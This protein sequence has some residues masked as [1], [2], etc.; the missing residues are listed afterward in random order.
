MAALL[1]DGTHSVLAM[2]PHADIDCLASAYA[3]SASFRISS[4]WA[5]F[6]LDKFA[7]AAAERYAI[8][9]SPELPA[10]TRRVIFVDT[11][12]A[13]AAEYPDLDGKEIFIIDHHQTGDTTRADASFI[14]VESPSCSELVVEILEAGGIEPSKEVAELLIM[15]ILF[16]TGRFRRGKA[17]TL[18]KCAS[19]LET[20]GARLE[21]SKLNPE[22]PMDGSEQTAILKGMQRMVFRSAGGCIVCCSH[23]SAY[24]SSVASAL[25]KTGCDVAFVASETD[26]AVRVTGRSGPK[27][28]DASIDLVALFERIADGFGGKSGGHTG[29]A[30]LNTDGEMEAILNSCAAECLEFLGSH[31]TRTTGTTPVHTGKTQ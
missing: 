21:S 6:K 13:R 17:S 23:T 11:N 29:A 10:E 28:I 31:S 14:D 25:L 18:K 3:L 7:L 19:L 24:E 1:A 27:G 12:E 15:G 9:P 22:I 8:Q 26:G 20:A 30:V 16:D 2:H 4:L 5:P